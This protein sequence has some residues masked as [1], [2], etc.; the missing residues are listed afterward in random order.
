MLS[1]GTSGN[2][3]PSI[4]AHVVPPSVDSNMWP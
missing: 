1:A 2:V 3:V 4:D